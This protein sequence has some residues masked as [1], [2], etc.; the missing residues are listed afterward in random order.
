[1]TRD[2]DAEKR[3]QDKHAV[4]KILVSEVIAENPK[5]AQAFA[6]LKDAGLTEQ[7]A[8]GEIARVL[9]Y[10]MRPPSG[11]A[12]NLS[13]RRARVEEGRREFDALLERIIRG[14]RAHD[15]LPSTD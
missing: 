10:C 9:E 8:R 15:V 3:K 12:P 7:H 2:D 14:E 5:A 1:M 11:K 13:A 4:G 6:V